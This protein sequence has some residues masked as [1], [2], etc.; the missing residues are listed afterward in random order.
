MVKMFSNLIKVF[1]DG[2]IITENDN[3][4]Y[5]N[6]VIK[7]ILKTDKIN[8]DIYESPLNRDINENSQCNNENE[9]IIN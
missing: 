6:K 2:I 7:K 8:N 4:L 5:T 3:V 1:H 9:K